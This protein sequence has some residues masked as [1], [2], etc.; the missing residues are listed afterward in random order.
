MRAATSN[1]GLEL[2]LLQQFLDVFCGKTRI[3]VG[4]QRITFTGSSLG[5][6]I[7]YSG[8]EICKN[9]SVKAYNGDTCEVRLSR[10]GAHFFDSSALCS[11]F[12]V[13]F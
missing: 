3:F 2:Y 9:E 5:P 8:I 6:S 11:S 1:D 10:F 12:F 13:L 4:F 7:N